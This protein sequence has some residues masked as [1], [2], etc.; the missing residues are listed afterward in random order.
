MGDR[1]LL[2]EVWLVIWPE[3]VGTRQLMAGVDFQQLE[4]F[5]QITGYPINYPTLPF[6]SLYLVKPQTTGSQF[7]SLH[8]ATSYTAYAKPSIQTLTPITSQE[9]SNVIWVIENQD[10]YFIKTQNTPTLSIEINRTSSDSHYSRLDINQGSAFPNTEATNGKFTIDNGDLYYIK[11][12]ATPSNWIEVHMASHTRNFKLVEYHAETKFPVN[13]TA[14]GSF[15]IR[16]G[17]LFL[18]KVRNTASDRAEIHI[19]D[20][21]QDY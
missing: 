16:G 5:F 19:A 3:H 15:T 20:G 1:K 9:S 4:A 14:N 18:I 13:D 17:D 7:F 6:N 21:E 12:R 2:E 10:L 11:S 8:N